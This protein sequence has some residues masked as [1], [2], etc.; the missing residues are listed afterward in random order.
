MPLIGQSCRE[1]EV[2][3]KERPAAC[4]GG[5]RGGGW[6]RGA[7]R[8]QE[9]DGEGG[10]E[11]EGRKGVKLEIEWR[12]NEEETGAERQGEGWRQGIG[13]RQ[14]AEETGKG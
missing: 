6:R 9:Q 7:A 3:S 12:Q 4:R 1:V 10:K 11:R 14:G 13:W 8:R 5:G 2:G